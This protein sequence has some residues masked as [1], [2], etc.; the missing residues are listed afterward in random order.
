L[1]ISFCGNFFATRARFVAQRWRMASAIR[2]GAA[3]LASELLEEFDHCS[4]VFAAKFVEA[5]NDLSCIAPVGS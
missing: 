5:L 4:L 2:F 3:A 1:Q